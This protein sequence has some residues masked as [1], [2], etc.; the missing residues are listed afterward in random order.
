[1]LRS[2]EPRAIIIQWH[3]KELGLENQKA[4]IEAM[5]NAGIITANNPT[6]VELNSEDLA[7]AAYLKA[8][9]EGDVV[10]LPEDIDPITHS[11]EVIGTR[12]KDLDANTIS[13]KIVGDIIAELHKQSMGIPQDIEFVS[14]ID[15]LANKTITAKYASVL[16]KYGVT[17]A[18]LQVIHN[19]YSIYNVN[20]KEFI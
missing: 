10:K 20:Q 18:I 6:I 16:R 4:L 7:K 13:I 15:I 9:T 5:V 11:I 8:I 3:G 2:S 17:R 14:A 12:Y 1:M 19:A